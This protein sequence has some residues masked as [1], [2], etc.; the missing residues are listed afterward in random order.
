MDVVGM[1]N[2][3]RSLADVDSN[4]CMVR[5]RQFAEAL[6]GALAN[7]AQADIEGI[8]FVEQI[9]VVAGAAGLPPRI[10][11]ALH[12]VRT[13]GNLAVHHHHSGDDEAQAALALCEEILAETRAYLPKGT[14]LNALT[15]FDVGGPEQEYPSN[16]EPLI[17]GILVLCEQEKRHRSLGLDVPAV[18][19]FETLEPEVLMNLTTYGLDREQAERARLV[20]VRSTDVPFSYKQ[21][22][23]LGALGLRLAGSFDA[24]VLKLIMPP[25]TVPAAELGLSPLA[26]AY[27]Q[28]LCRT[29][30]LEGQMS[31]PH[32][33]K[34]MSAALM[35]A[36]EEWFDH[37]D[38]P[39]SIS[40][41]E[42]RLATLA[43]FQW[44]GSVRQLL[45]GPRVGSGTVWKMFG[46]ETPGWIGGNKE[47]TVRH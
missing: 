33:R 21:I 23:G 8:P 4:A 28:G 12:N 29:R 6:T 35:H 14:L 44:A 31:R 1:L 20:P 40:N 2:T 38:W 22:G 13:V 41:K 3:A 16:A 34:H 32:I 26:N 37:P 47:A 30:Y 43:A 25:T 17:E 15:E 45:I 5:C 46:Q 19:S 18:A 11:R 42:L 10:I 24:Q 7:E 39:D 27:L 9:G 36:R